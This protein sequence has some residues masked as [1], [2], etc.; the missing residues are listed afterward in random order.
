MHGC[1]R[2][3]T[4]D[5]A[6]ETRSVTKEIVRYCRR[7][8]S[9]RSILISGSRGSGK[10][11]LVRW[12][13]DKARWDQTISAKP[14]IVAL[15]GPALFL[16]AKAAQGKEQVDAKDPGSQNPLLEE[17]GTAT[18]APKPASNPPKSEDGTPTLAKPKP[19][20]AKA[21]EAGVDFAT[22][23]LKGITKALYRSYVD[24]LT[25][26]FALAVKKRRRRTISR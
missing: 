4:A 6:C 23:V 17:A 25:D 7:E 18:E 8:T 21:T 13:I 10:T 1:L 24:Q 15:H 9:G 12:A 26:Y 14:F 3:L 22:A 16:T 2:R 5:D 19:E 20:D 11:S